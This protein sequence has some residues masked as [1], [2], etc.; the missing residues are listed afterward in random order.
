MQ[1]NHVVEPVSLG[2][3]HHNASPYPIEGDGVIEVHALVLPSHRDGRLLCFGPF[4]HEVC[5]GLGLDYYLWVIRYVES[6]DLESPL[7]IPSRGEA[8]PTISP[9]PCDETTWTGD[10]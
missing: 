5:Q 3:V 2:G 6:H 4:C 1:S 10:F 7:S 8:V 9:S